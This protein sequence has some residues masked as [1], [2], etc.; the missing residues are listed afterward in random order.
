MKNIDDVP[1]KKEN[2]ET[3]SKEK[4]ESEEDKKLTSEELDKAKVG[5]DKIDKKPEKPTEEDTTTPKTALDTLTKPG[6]EGEERKKIIKRKGKIIQSKKPGEPGEEDKKPITDKLD[7]VKVDGIQID[8]K[9]E[10]PT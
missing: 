7:K 6:E 4:P 3:L 1:L 8:K 5:G 10:Q 9:P 2:K